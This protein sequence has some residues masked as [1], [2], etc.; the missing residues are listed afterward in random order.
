MVHRVQVREISND[1]GFGP[2]NLQPHPGKQWAPAVVGKGADCPHFVGGAAL[3]G[4]AAGSGEQSAR[5]DVT[6][7][8]QR[9]SC[10]EA[11]PLHQVRGAT[12]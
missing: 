4:L 9:H 11:V 8:Q 3:R 10:L 5:P 1:E 2:L 12:R 6:G 7:T